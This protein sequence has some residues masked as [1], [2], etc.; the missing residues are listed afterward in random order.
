M[1]FYLRNKAAIIRKLR[2]SL[3]SGIQT[4][5]YFSWRGQEE[6]HN[7]RQAYLVM[8]DVYRQ[9]QYERT[10]NRPPPPS[11]LSNGSDLFGD[12]WYPPGHER[13]INFAELPIPPVGECGVRLLP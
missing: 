10:F 4:P 9:E 5:V 6:L 8:F 1:V 3:P 11:R 7:D 2:F 13:A 12:Y